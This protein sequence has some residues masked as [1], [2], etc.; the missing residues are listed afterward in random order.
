MDYIVQILADPKKLDLPR[1]P[2]VYSIFSSSTCRFVGETDNLYQAI[3]DHFRPNEPNIKL[4]YFMLSWK[5]KILQ[6]QIISD[7]SPGV[8][9]SL[10]QQWIQ[11]YHPSDNIPS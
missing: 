4:R 10:L 6:Y 3:I 11:L 1:S 2:A 7:M 8:R 9:K 5:P